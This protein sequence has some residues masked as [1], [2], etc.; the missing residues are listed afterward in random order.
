[1]D[2]E[3]FFF[4]RWYR[5]RKERI[6]KEEEEKRRQEELRKRQEEPSKEEIE[7]RK[8][9]L[10]KRSAVPK[11]QVV[12]GGHAAVVL[13]RTHKLDVNDDRLV[14]EEMEKLLSPKKEVQKKEKR[15]KNDSVAINM[16][17]E[18]QKPDADM[19][20]KMSKKQYAGFKEAHD[21]GAEMKLIED[22]IA[23]DAPDRAVFKFPYY[24]PE[25]FDR[26]KEVEFNYVLVKSDN[27]VKVHTSSK[28]WL[29]G[30]KTVEYADVEEDFE[31]TMPTLEATQSSIFEASSK[32]TRK[33][34]AILERTQ[35]T[36]EEEVN[37][38]PGGRDKK[39]VEKKGGEKKPSLTPEQV[40][41]I[42][43]IAPMEFLRRTN[44]GIQLNMR[45][46]HQISSSHYYPRG[47]R[48]TNGRLN[49][50]YI[51]SRMLRRDML[52][53]ASWPHYDGKIL[54]IFHMSIEYM[55]EIMHEAGLLYEKEDVMLVINRKQI[56]VAGDI[57]GKF[58][59]M[60]YQIVMTLNNDNESILFL[61]DLVDRGKR[62]MD[63]VLLM[64]VL[65]IINP[66]K[67]FFLAGNHEMLCVNKSHGF[68][69]E[70]VNTLGTGGGN[71]FYAAANELFQKMPT[72]A[73]LQEAI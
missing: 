6:R 44:K 3:Y 21:I 7:K 16:E 2:S 67:F 40:Y 20:D 18:V 52:R 13:E 54:H 10:A 73:V 30:L 27:D 19:V 36:L 70:C 38:A 51:A 29:V 68:Y 47:I 33:Q 34:S 23:K 62:S 59:D 65:K 56:K 32:V 37:R 58:P 42:S 9:E 26:L 22:E 5:S 39:R 63:V 46:K 41:E 60:V 14:P 24:S 25:F 31:L 11:K 45:C 4:I 71:R 72:C 43:T 48:L 35:Q 17:E 64:C 15:E 28:D 49:V 12:I 8:Q 57:H 61:G 1:M 55:I 66:K 53:I 50:S 69:K